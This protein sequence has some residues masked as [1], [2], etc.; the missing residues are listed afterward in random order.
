MYGIPVNSRRM[1]E[2]TKQF[3]SL[4]MVE[5]PKHREYKR[6][7]VQELKSTHA[8]VRTANWKYCCTM[9]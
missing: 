8:K 6:P 5:L 4:V 7:D 9:E 3:V 1:K 2:D